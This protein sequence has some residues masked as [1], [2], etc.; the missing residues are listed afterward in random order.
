MLFFLGE[1]MLNV[2][3]SILHVDGSIS[4]Y[5]NE[6]QKVEKIAGIGGYLLTN[7]RVRDTFYKILGEEIPF[8]NHH[9]EHA[10]IE[11]IRWCKQKNI[12][13]LIVRTDSIYSYKIFNN[14]KKIHGQEDK[15]FLLQYLMLEYSFEH[16]EVQYFNR[17]EN[18]LSHNLSRKYLTEFIKKNSLKKHDTVTEIKKEH[19]KD[20]LR[21][22]ITSNIMSFL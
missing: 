10:V 14:C 21:K 5:L 17:K 4:Q 18:D 12:R 8:I 9:E 3:H 19:T 20:E 2:E 13:Q 1:K 7:N 15:F 11:G 6:S 22:A 16:L